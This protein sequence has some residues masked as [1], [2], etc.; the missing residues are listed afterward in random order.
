MPNDVFST[1]FYRSSTTPYLNLAKIL[2]HRNAQ[3]RTQKALSQDLPEDKKWYKK[4]NRRCLHV[5]SK[6]STE[7][8]QIQKGGVLLILILFLFQILLFLIQFVCLLTYFV[9]LVV[10]HSINKGEE[11]QKRGKGTRIVQFR[12]CPY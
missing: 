1:L 12:L 2:S 5:L 9:H 8:V 7:I 10:K 6:S 3:T 11:G 4:S